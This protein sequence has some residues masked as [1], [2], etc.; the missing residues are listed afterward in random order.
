MRSVKTI[1]Q[2]GAGTLGAGWATFFAVKGF[3]VNLYDANPEQTRKGLQQAGTQIK[4]LFDNGMTPA[5]ISSHNM[6]ARIKTA[7]SLEEAASSADFIQESAAE[8]Y[9]IKRA[10]YAELDKMT[11]ADVVL[12]S[13]SSGLLMSEIQKAATRP[14]RC[15]IAHPFNPPYLVPLVELVPGESTSTET[16]VETKQFFESL[17][18]TPVVL[19]KE[20]PG[21]IANRLAAALWREAIDLVLNGV[22]S[23]EDVD[24]AVSA[25]PGLRWAIMGQH[26]IYHLGGG[27]GGLAAFIDH[28]APALEM[29]WRD[30]A[31]WK[32]FPDGA[33]EKLLAGVEEETAGRDLG[34]VMRWRDE[35]LI[36]V[37]KAVRD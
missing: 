31:D 7:A 35:K 19:N 14:E 34:E 11:A 28:L 20:T 1:G 17:G 27:Q 13:S 25:G 3:D 15:L 22:A 37:L 6:T 24:K 16:V 18:K 32:T 2:I 30:L 26:M 33:R 29:W 5:G 10:V 36:R 12:A 9:E 8:D 21:H 4:Y 23:V